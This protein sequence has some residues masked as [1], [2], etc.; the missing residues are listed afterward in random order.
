MED[1]PEKERKEVPEP[2]PVSDNGV[3]YEA[4]IWGKARGLEQNGGYIAAYDLATNR[5]LWLLK[6]YDVVYDQEMEGD[7][8]DLFIEELSLDDEGRLLVTDE[9]GEV[10]F[11]DVE[12]RRVIETPEEYR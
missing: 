8:Q 3:R 1:S 4:V 12:N 9:R 5:E 6:V 7:K 2:E 11:V 10:Y